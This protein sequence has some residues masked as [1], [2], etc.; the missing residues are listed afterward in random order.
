MMSLLLGLILASGHG[1][2][3][4]PVPPEPPEPP[5]IHM[6]LATSLMGEGA[7]LGV[8]LKDV[9]ADTVKAM[10]LKE[11]RGALVSKVVEDSPAAKA[12]L[13]KDDVIQ[14][15]NGHDVESAAQ[16]RRMMG[17]AVPGRTARLDVMRGGRELNVAVT[18]GKPEGPSCCMLGKGAG[19]GDDDV[20]AYAFR[21][22]GDADKL[23]LKAEKLRELAEEKELESLDGLEGLEELN[24]LDIEA[25]RVEKSIRIY[26]GG[27]TRLGVKLSDLTPQL[28]EYFGLKD[29]TGVLITEVMKDTP[30]EKAGLKAGDVLLTVGG[31]K[32]EDPGDVRESLGD[33]EGAVELTVMRDRKELK[34]I[35]DLE[36][37]EKHRPVIMRDKQENHT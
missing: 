36:K 22:K 25:P 8:V 12:G 24:E 2:P 3:V 35:A 7:Y 11:E 21:V 29:R 1:A 4:P 33:R 19:R 6:A 5:E 30:A 28:A 32:V 27:R 34:L 26:V 20:R 23:R 14:S 37:G 17:E 16:L 15:L 9:D 31:D 10:H 13:K 18:P